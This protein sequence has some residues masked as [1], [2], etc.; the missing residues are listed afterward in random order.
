[1]GC[2]LRAVRGSVS[3][4]AWV[5]AEALSPDIML[6]SFH[7]VCLLATMT[8]SATAL[9]IGMPPT[10]LHAASPVATQRAATY[11]SAASS[12][13]EQVK[14]TVAASKVV[15]YSKS[16]CPFC[17]KTKGLLDSMDILY[18]AVELD[19]LDNGD[20][21]QT[22]LLDLTGQR[23]VPN[24]FIGGKHLGGNDDTQRAAK[25][26]ALQELLK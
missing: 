3:R 12:L 6:R 2:Y 21:L 13:E 17:Q 18:T 23:T 8:R 16:W 4:T 24:V 11:A 15:V 1:M 19:E 9:R 7:R 22:T 5:E 25:S 26:G 14:E 10:L 20:A